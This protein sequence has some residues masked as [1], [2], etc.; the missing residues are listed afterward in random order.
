M[1]EVVA[2]FV[3]IFCWIPLMIRVFDI[4]SEEIDIKFVEFL[5]KAIAKVGK[6]S[7]DCYTSNARNYPLLIH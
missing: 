6:D 4:L 2:L 1:T 5:D 7:Y 3:P